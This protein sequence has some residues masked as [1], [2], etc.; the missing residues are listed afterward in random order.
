MRQSKLGDSPEETLQTRQYGLPQQ[1]D[2]LPLMPLRLMF[3]FERK[4]FFE[5]G[6]EKA[7]HPKAQERAAHAD[8]RQGQ[9]ERPHLI[10]GYWLRSFAK[11]VSIN[12][13]TPVWLILLFVSRPI[14]SFQPLFRFAKTLQVQGNSGRKARSTGL[15]F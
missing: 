7:Q 4:E 5:R 2:L 1:S 3:R 13:T 8:Y 10:H 9:T 15:R 12:Q 11:L 14:L 6:D